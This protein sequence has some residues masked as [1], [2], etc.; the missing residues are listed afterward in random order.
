MLILLGAVDIKAPRAF[1]VWVRY[2]DGSESL[3][4]LESS[5]M[6]GA[7]ALS[8]RT[9]ATITRGNWAPGLTSFEVVLG[10]SAEE[11][12]SAYALLILLCDARRRVNVLDEPG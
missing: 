10:E 8:G 1:C 2:I 12:G 4:D 6:T 11:A 3:F 9:A 5:F 7:G